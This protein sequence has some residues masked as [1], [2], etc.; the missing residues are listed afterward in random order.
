MR[1]YVLICDC[2]RV[3][4]Y[5]RAWA[6][7]LI[8][9]CCGSARSCVVFVWCMCVCMWRVYVGVCVCACACACVC[10]CVCGHLVDT[11]L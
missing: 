5:D 9:A 6:S 10:V 1:T 2:A 4:V 11:V 8:R 7:M 3:R